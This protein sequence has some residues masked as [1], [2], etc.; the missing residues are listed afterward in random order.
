MI[1]DFNGLGLIKRDE[2][3]EMRFAELLEHKQTYEHYK[4]AGR[5]ESKQLANWVQKQRQ[6]KKAGQLHPER[7]RLIEGV[8]FSW[9]SSRAIE[10]GK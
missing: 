6:L 4:V 1:L 3:W 9:D 8:G 2:K 5:D 10:L 7:I